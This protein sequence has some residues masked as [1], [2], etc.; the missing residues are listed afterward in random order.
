MRNI[1][2]QCTKCKQIK[3]FDDFYKNKSTID[4]YQSWCKECKKSIDQTYNRKEDNK[5]YQNKHALY[6]TYSH[7]LS[8]ADDVKQLGKLLM[9]K[10]A[11][12]GEWI[13]PTNL[14]V[15]DRIRALNG[16]VTGNAENRF[17]CNDYCKTE[18]PIFHK[19]KHYSGTIR[20]SVEVNPEFRQIVFER[21]QY[22]CQNCGK[23]K[24][25]IS[26]HCHHINPKISDPI[27]DCDI[28]N[29]ITLCVDCHKLAHQ[30]DGCKY[31][32]LKCL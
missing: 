16:Q 25:E 2:K 11:Y 29:G 32:Q 9:V 4:G 22:K 13:F 7:Q 26:L 23:H 21:D 18:C 20:R 30:K 31:N 8:F 12:C 10:C 15:R 3:P 28:D 17:Y 14:Q 1:M 6:N 5:Q 19:H 24:S 27:S